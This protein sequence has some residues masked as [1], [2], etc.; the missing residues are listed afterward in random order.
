MGLVSG[1]VGSLIN[2]VSEQPAWLRLPSQGSLQ[3]N[4][5][6]SLVDGLTRRPPTEHVA[7]ASASALGA[8]FFHTINN[9]ST[10]RYSVVLT[11][12]NLR[13]FDLSDGSEKTVNFPNGK[14]YLNVTG[15]PVSSFTCTTIADFTFVTNLEKVVTEDTASAS[16]QANTL[17]AYI[18]EA[19]YNCNYSIYID[20]TLRASHTTA[21]TGSQPDT[22]VIAAALVT[23]LAAWGGGSWSMTQDGSVISMAHTSSPGTAHTV[24]AHDSSGDTACVAWGKSIQRFED[25]PRRGIS[26]MV[27]EVTGSATNSFDS[28]WVTFDGTKLQWIETVKPEDKK[29]PE[30]T[31]MPW[32]LI[33]NLD[34]TFTFDKIT[35]WQYR[36][37]GD[38]NSNPTPSFIGKSINDVLVWRNRLV[39]L[40]DQNVIASRTGGENFFDFYAN[41]ATTRLDTDP[42]DIAINSN[43]SQVPLAKYGLAFGTDLLVFSEAGQ[44]KLSSANQA[45]TPDTVRAD[46]ASA[47]ASPLTARP[48][49]NGIVIHFPFDKGGK[50]AVREGML[51]ESGEKLIASDVTVHLPSY[52]S[53]SITKMVSAKN[54]DTLFVLVDG[55]PGAI[56]V[57]RWYVE[58]NEKL[59]SSWSKWTFP[60]GDTILDI[61]HIESNL[62][63]LIQRSTGVFIEK[64][65]LDLAHTDTGLSFSCRLDR[66]VS[67]TGTYNSGT[68]LTTWTVPYNLTGLTVRG[69]WG[70]GFD[71]RE[72]LQIATTVA[73]AAAG[74]VTAVG[75]WSAHPCIFGVPFTH[76]YRLSTIYLRQG[77]GEKG[78]A[79]M[80]DGHLRLRNVFFNHNNT[81]A[82]EVS[83]AYPS[84][85]TSSYPFTIH[86]LGVTSVI[87]ELTLRTGRFRVPAR[88]RNT[89]LTIEITGDSHFPCSI[90]GFD[91]EG[92]FTLR[93]RKV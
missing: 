35:D 8:A 18:K 56:G 45:L 66:K 27:V 22:T 37:A 2:G 23:Q 32:K 84:R 91:W 58:S 90:L 72:G 30:P 42:I 17:Y 21:A 49:T 82:Y 67:L 28:Y 80:T 10:Q 44:H 9:S 60:T 7:R 19:R 33:N 64:V 68:G 14:A 29:R 16:S 83:V 25:L 69:V 5:V 75:D 65:Q 26:G 87:G 39:L 1:S 46:E 41:T 88:G 13:V 70:A 74:T 79:A 55:E 73:N 3:E 61:A 47:Y 38:E 52:L 62:Y 89:D 81:G 54:R 40:A 93:S 59:Q 4:M 24:Q 63:I 15:A 12:G 34:G 11:N 77:G 50:S 76:R 48:A 36:R 78:S 53:G 85:T 71:G 57:Y 43:S 20:G 51:D 31:T 92:E 6:S 86:K